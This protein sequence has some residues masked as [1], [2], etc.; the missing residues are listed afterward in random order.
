MI[1]LSANPAKGVSRM[2]KATMMLSVAAMALFAGSE[3]MAADAL[4][5]TLVPVAPV[6]NSQSTNVFGISESGGASGVI[7]GSWTD[8]RAVEHGY[9]GPA[10]GSSYTTF[11]DP[12][13]PGPGTEPRAINNNGYV[14][15]FSNSQN[16]SISGDIPFE[17]DPSGNITEVTKGGTLLNGLI[18]GINNRRGEFAGSYINSSLQAV[19]YLG[20]DGAYKQGIKLKGFKNTGY[21]ARA[22]NNAGD[23][24]GWYYDSSGVQHGLLIVGGTAQQLDPSEANLSSNALEGI[25][26]KGTITGFWTDTSGIIHGYYYKMNS[27]KFTTIKV[28]GSSTFV[29]AWG[30]DDSNRIAI[31]SDAGPYIYCPH[32]TACPPGARGS[33]KPLVKP[34][35]QLP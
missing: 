32:G 13:S 19:G 22:I 20:K 27:K 28:P 25:N 15:G 17:R 16:G 5:G 18:Q 11:D 35:P 34:K 3:V 29:Q 30:V 2:N 31:G 14:T 10:N 7:T 4:K 8:A 1:S 21:A 23:I 26:D 6:P 24:V 12:K 9:V 33:Y